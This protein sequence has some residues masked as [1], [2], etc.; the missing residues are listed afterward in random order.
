MES[1]NLKFGTFFWRVTASHMITYFIMGLIAISFLDYENAF[2][3]PPLS[4][5]MKP[6]DSPSVALGPALQVFRGLVFSIAIWFFKDSFLFKEYGWLKLWGLLVGLSILSTVG[7][8]P[9]SIEGFIY[10]TIPFQTQLKGYLEVLPQ[11][12]LFSL[13]V[14]FW[15]DR[16]GRWLNIVS[17]ILVIIIISLSIMGFLISVKNLNATVWS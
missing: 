16:P 14:Y 2:Q 9:G 12:L 13:L 6:V 17:A 4:Y 1:N 5:L 3:N 10:T 7:A 11:T 15:Y 8:S